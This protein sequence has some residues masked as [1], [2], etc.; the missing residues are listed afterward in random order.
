[1]K[2]LFLDFDG[3][4]NTWPKPDRTGIFHKPCCFN[5]EQLMKMVPDLNIVVSSSWRIHG[6]E[7]VRDIL[8]DNGI[9]AARVIGITGHEHTDSHDR[10]N[11]RGNQIKCWLERNPEVTKFAIL[12][13][14]SDME[15]FMDR[16]VKTNR[17]VGLSMADIEEVAKLVNE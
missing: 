7:A 14:E 3:V 16:L 1:M 13:D 8:V 6:Y 4:L 11:H 5:L 10:W 12:D 15:P 2:V 17:F 9:E